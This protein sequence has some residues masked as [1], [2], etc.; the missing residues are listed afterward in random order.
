M[1]IEKCVI[2]GCEYFGVP[3]GALYDMTTEENAAAIIA[4]QQA[5]EDA[6]KASRAAKAFLGS[7]DWKIL[8]HQDEVAMGITTSL[9]EAEYTN[10]LVARREARANV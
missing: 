10:L 1:I 5:K 4:E 6:V 8:R 3:E 9:T 2:D 7:S